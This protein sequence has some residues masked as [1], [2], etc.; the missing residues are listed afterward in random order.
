MEKEISDFKVARS[1]RKHIA[2]VG[3]VNTGKS[4]LLNTIMSDEISIVSNEKGTTTDVVY[5]NME[6]DGVGAVVFMDTAGFN[7][8]T[9]LGEKREKKTWNAIE[10]SDL[11][12]F[13]LDE[14]IS[15][16]I[17]NYEKLKKFNIPIIPIVNK[18]FYNSRELDKIY[19]EKFEE[20]ILKLNFEKDIQKLLKEIRRN[21]EE[22]DEQL[23]HK[24]YKMVILVMPQDESAPKGRLIAPQAQTIRELVDKD[25]IT[26]IATLE[27]LE[28]IV[29]NFPMAE[30]V[31]TDSKVFSEVQKILQGRVPLTSFSILFAQSKGD[32]EYFLESAKKLDRVKDGFRVLISEACSHSPKEEDIGRVKIPKLLKKLNENIEIDFV[33][34]GDFERMKG[35]DLVIH[36]GACM[37]N[38]KYMQNKVDFCKENKIP[39]TNYGIVFKKLS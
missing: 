32:I 28:D 37:Y 17:E 39:M 19:F 20:R 1:L 22:E 13:V 14:N 4:K 10:K 30:L 23:L 34:G 18:Y 11:I 29:R 2:I 16:N 31:I 21:L 12:L 24:N 7:D 8:G 9:A 35:Y 26:V 3:N 38:K 5:K 36:C 15:L 27:N 6:I 33:R 25:I